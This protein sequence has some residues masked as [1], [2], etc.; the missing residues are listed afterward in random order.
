MVSLGREFFESAAGYHLGKPQARLLIS[1]NRP[2]VYGG[3]LVITIM[4]LMP[5]INLMVPILAIV[6]MVHV[7]HG[8][9]EAGASPRQHLD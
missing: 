3:G 1:R 5:F 7:Y 8:L 9:P 4:T 2:A 6:W